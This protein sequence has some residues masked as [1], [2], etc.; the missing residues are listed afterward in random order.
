[1][2]EEAWDTHQE[3]GVGDTLKRKEL[4]IRNQ[5]TL[6]QNQFYLLQTGPITEPVLPSFPTYKMAVTIPTQ[7]LPHSQMILSTALCRTFIWKPPDLVLHMGR[8]ERELSCRGCWMRKEKASDG[9]CRVLAPC[10][11]EQYLLPSDLP[12]FHPHKLYFKFLSVNS[13]YS[14][15]LPARA[16]QAQSGLIM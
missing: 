2:L 15:T 3:L 7:P 1:M 11:H 16:H 4:Q 13:I 9:P 8:D 14:W 12:I 10:W 6:C 5:N